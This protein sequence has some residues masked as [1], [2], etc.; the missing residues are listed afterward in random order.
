M[1]RIKW[2][3]VFVAFFAL[4]LLTI[5]LSSCSSQYSLSTSCSPTGGGQITPSS[6][7]YDKQVQVNVIASPASG[8]RFDHWE[9]SAS[10]SSPSLPLLMDSNKKVTAFFTKV[11]TVSVSATPS[12]G[13]DISPGNATY[14]SGK[15]VTLIATPARYYKFNGWGGDASG[16]SDH[17]TIIVDSDKQIVAS[18]VKITYILQAQVDSP[19]GGTI[20][21]SSSTLDAGTSATITATPS[22]GYRFDHWGGSATGASNPLNILMDT[23]KTLT[24]YFTKV[25]TL[26]VS[27]SPNNSGNTNLSSGLFDAGTVATLTATTQIFPY[28]F[29]HWS[30]TDNDNINPTNVTMTSDKSVTAYFKQL[31]PGTQQTKND[32]LSGPANIATFQLKEGQWVQGQLNG[33][34]FDLNSQIVDANNNVVKDLGR[35]VR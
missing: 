24:A 15:Q 33:G 13:G 26:T 2:S 1:K 16:D 6:G 34:P 11:Y 29:D 35:N 18:F 5:T 10:G 12:V 31:S 20:N 22:K 21:P 8:Y 30:G 7:T 32:Q 28:G 25:Y 3:S 17:M 27:S 23:N 9:G 19:V 14:D 4:A